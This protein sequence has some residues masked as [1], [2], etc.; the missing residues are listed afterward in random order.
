MYTIEFNGKTFKGDYR[1]AMAFLVDTE[2]DTSEEALNMKFGNIKNAKAQEIAE[3]TA[4]KLADRK[5]KR[6]L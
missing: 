5:A 1:E 2:Y 6:S 4:R 3:E